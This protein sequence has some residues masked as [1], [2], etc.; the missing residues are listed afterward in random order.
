MVNVDAKGNWCS[1]SYGNVNH[2]GTSSV[3][4][5]VDGNTIANTNLAAID[6]VIKVNVC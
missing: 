2:I 4:A 6:E 3:D 1:N 5:N